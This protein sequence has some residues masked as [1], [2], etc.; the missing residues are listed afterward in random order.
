MEILNKPLG[1]MRMLVAAASD[2]A[3]SKR[4]ILR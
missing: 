3:L 4:W 2:I 1:V